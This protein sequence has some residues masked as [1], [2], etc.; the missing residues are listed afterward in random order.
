MGQLAVLKEALK[1]GFIER[2]RA[3]SRPE[4]TELARWISG[5]R[6]FSLKRIVRIKIA[7]LRNLV[8]SRNSVPEHHGWNCMKVDKVKE[9]RE[10]ADHR[11]QVLACTQWK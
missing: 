7:S 5:G 2:E 9:I 8:C 6:G 1:L 4:D 3:E 11:G 10:M